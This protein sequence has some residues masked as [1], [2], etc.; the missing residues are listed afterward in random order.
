MKM[1]KILILLFLCIQ[2]PEIS[3]FRCICKR[4]SITQFH[5]RLSFQP[6][7]VEPRLHPLTIINKMPII[8]NIYNRYR[9]IQN[10]FRTQLPM[11]QYLWPNDDIRLRIFLVLSMIFMFI[12]KYINVKVPFML[13]RAV[14]GVSKATFTTQTVPS[15]IQ[16][17]SLSFLFYGLSRA[18]SVVCS[19]IKT[20]LFAHVCQN[21]LRKFA[22]QI[23]SHL[24]SLDSDFHLQTPSGTISVAY[25]R[26][27]RGFQTMLFQIV[28]SVAPTALELFLVSNVLFRRFGAYLFRILNLS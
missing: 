17:T 28:F 22:S 13:Q 23:F 25:V 24:H 2:T 16:A 26:A 27:V 12:G 10:F 5:E 6:N 3:S 21:V 9:L 8:S 15:V 11:L 14:D 7:E 4:L 1:H 19:E 18:L 20:C